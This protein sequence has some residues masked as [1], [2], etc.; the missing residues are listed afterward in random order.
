MFTGWTRVSEITEENIFHNSTE[1]NSTRGKCTISSLPVSV[2][3]NIWLK[4]IIECRS[5]VSSYIIQ[6]G[7]LKK[8]TVFLPFPGG[9]DER[10][11]RTGNEGNSSLL[12]FLVTCLIFALLVVVIFFA[13]KLRRAHILW[14]RGKQTASPFPLKNSYSVLFQILFL[15]LSRN[16]N[17]LPSELYASIGMGWVNVSDVMLF[18]NV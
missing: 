14:K 15:S 3:L 18:R 8:L 7:I 12:V 16:A 10:Q 5:Y 2:H 9:F 4:V 6:R 11:K 1:G 13:I 17:P